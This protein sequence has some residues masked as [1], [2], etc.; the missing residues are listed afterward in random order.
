MFIWVATTY[1]S[2]GIEQIFDK[3]GY[4][5]IVSDSSDIGVTGI[6]YAVMTI[7]SCIIA[8]ITEVCC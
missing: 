4:S 3:F 6:G 1:L 8:P 2:L 5:T 7:Y